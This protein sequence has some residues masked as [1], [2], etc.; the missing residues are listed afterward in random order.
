MAHAENY[1]RG[2]GYRVIGLAVAIHNLAALGLYQQLDFQQSNI[3]MRKPLA[4]TL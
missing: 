3:L 2:Q 4:A 1:A